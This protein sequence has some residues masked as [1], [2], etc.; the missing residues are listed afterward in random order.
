[1]ATCLI[2]KKSGNS[3]EFTQV[4]VGY[5]GTEHRCK[6]AQHAEKMVHN[7]CI[8]FSVTEDQT[9][10]QRQDGCRVRK[11]VSVSVSL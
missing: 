2:N 11:V 5:D 4:R 6:V 8:V 10:V 9:H 3:L 1:M 7:R